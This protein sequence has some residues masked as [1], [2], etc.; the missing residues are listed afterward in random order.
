S[1]FAVQGFSFAGMG[2]NNGMAFV[3][4]KDW[5]DR[6]DDSLSAQAVAGRGMAAMSQVKDAMIFVFA[7]PAMPELGVAAGFSM[8]L[9][10]NA[11]QGHE[12]LLQAR[13]QLLGMAAQSELL[14]NVRPNGQEDTPQLRVDVDVA[15]AAALS[16][17][18]SDRK[19]VVEGK[20]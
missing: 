4:L 13:N 14:R 19:S 20:G 8:F 17:P 10:D 7:P 5:G 1:T 16:L 11:A 15:K 18:Q 9:Q 12:A 2:Q 3:K 6:K